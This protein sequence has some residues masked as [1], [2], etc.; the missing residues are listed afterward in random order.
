MQRRDFVTAS[1]AASIL[2]PAAWAADPIRT[3]MIGTGNRG[4]YVL[5]VIL[6]QPNVK[7]TALCDIK[8]DRL[9]RAA[10]LATRDNPATVRDYQQL[11]ARKDVDA[12][13]RP[14][15]CVREAAARVA[16]RTRVSQDWLN[17]GVKGFMSARGDFAAF[18]ELDHATPFAARGASTPQNLRLYCRS[19]NQGQARAHF[20]DA[21]IDAAIARGRLELAATQRG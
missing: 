4:G 9:D 17:D 7:V 8:P 1:V 3:G 16:A 19:H 2:R 12:V 5:G 6:Q 21:H 11:L 10:S 13:F 15:T 20:G 14:A 18:L